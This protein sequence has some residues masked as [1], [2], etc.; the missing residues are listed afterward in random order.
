VIR[1]RDRFGY[2]GADGVTDGPGG[3]LRDFVCMGGESGDINLLN[4]ER[5]NLL[6]GE[7]RNGKSGK[8]LVEKRSSKIS[9]EEDSTLTNSTLTNIRK[10]EVDIMQAIENHFMQPV[11]SGNHFMQPDYAG[12]KMQP[13]RSGNHFMQPDYAG[14]SFHADSHVT[15]R[16]LTV[17]VPDFLPKPH[18]TAPDFLPKPQFVRFTRLCHQPSGPHEITMHDMSY[19][20]QKRGE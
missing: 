9:R 14:K 6:N 2:V 4:G 5:R 7:R 15:V 17:S 16:D 13:V 20:Q 18:V 1:R 19:F 8:T 3:R 10:R 12:N 11:R